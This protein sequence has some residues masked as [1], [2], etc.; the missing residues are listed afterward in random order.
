MTFQDDRDRA[1]PAQEDGDDELS[2]I[3]TLLSFEEIASEKHDEIRAF[4]AKEPTPDPKSYATTFTWLHD[5]GFAEL[6]QL[7][8]CAEELATLVML[9]KHKLV[10]EEE[11]LVSMPLPEPPFRLQVIWSALLSDD[12]E[13]DSELHKLCQEQSMQ[14]MHRLMLLTDQQLEAAE[15]LV[16]TGALGADLT[17]QSHWKVLR[18]HGII[19]ADDARQGLDRAITSVMSVNHP[20]LRQGLLDILRPLD[21]AY[22][23]KHI[24]AMRAKQ[25]KAT[26]LKWGGGALIL[27]AVFT[28]WWLPKKPPSCSDTGV[29]NTLR[30]IAREVGFDA[31]L[32]DPSNRSAMFVTVAGQ[33]EVGYDRETRTRGC[34]A[35][36]GSRD[37]TSKIG[38]EIFP[39]PPDSNKFSV[40]TRPASYIYRKFSAADP[41]ANVGAPVGREA[42]TA[43]LKEGAKHGGFTKN[44]TLK[45]EE[46]AQAN[47]I[48]SVNPTANCTEVSENHYR[49]PVEIDYQDSLM[50]VVGRN[51][52]LTLKGDFTFIKDNDVWKVSDDF[53]TE[54]AAV[55]VD[56]RLQHIYGERSPSSD[57]AAPSNKQP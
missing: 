20:Y 33:Q 36:M 2:P 51:T 15:R 45:T 31:L 13:H 5:H 39:S 7:L 56:A 4:V 19:S 6:D 46:A 41:D 11:C 25:R 32:K 38:F 50:G 26:F 43:A 52:L 14:R 12:P 21:P 57:E 9:Y 34:I 27:L 23:G 24:D 55:M 49:C 42:M 1:N 48:L 29:H 35:F 40:Q 44:R 54:F 53:W 47:A 28:Y 3:E 17:L 10:T 30:S 16:Q 22:V 37:K 8:L 18:D